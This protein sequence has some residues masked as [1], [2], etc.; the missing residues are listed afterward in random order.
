[1]KKILIL[2]GG[3]AGIYTAKNLQKQNLE[4]YEIELISDNNYFIFQPLL[5]EVASG[6]IYSSD[7]VTPIRQMLKGIK[8]R[9]AEISSLDFNNKRVS[10]LQGFKKSTHSIQYDHLIIAL[11]QVSNLDIVKGLKDHAFTMRSLQDAYDLRNHIL[12]CLELADVTSN[13]GLKKR[14]LNIVVIGGGFSGVETIGEI[15]EMIDRLIPYYSSIKKS[16]L[17]FHIVEFADQ[18]LPDM[19]KKVGQYTLK[20]FK[21]NNINVHLKTALEE[22]TQYQVFL[23]NKKNI[24]THTVISTIG[25]TV[26]K[27]IKDC[28]L[29]LQ[30]GKIITKGS[31]EVEGL[32]NV[33]AV[34]DAALIPNKDKKNMLY[35]KKKIAYAPPNAQ[36]AVRQGKLLA[37][38]IKAKILGDNLS[39]FH[40]TSK[41][42]LA[43]L[44]SR[45]GVG[46]IFF[47]TV[48]G[49]IAWLIWRAFYL[50]FLPSFA[51]KIRVLTGWIVE[52]LV[53]RNAVMTRALKNDAV[54]YQ[55]FKKGDVVFKEGM[56]AD[57]F[58]IV[59]K[60]SFKNTFTKTSSG[61]KF[62]KFY[63]VNDHFGARVLLSGSRRT[64][65]IE[66][67]EDSKVVKI[68]R[69][70][71]KVM[72]KHF[73]PMKDYF[74]N[75]IK[76]NF[77]K[78]D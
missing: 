12:G 42:S 64:G 55:N 39:D 53:P 6:T 69:D 29:A 1:M 63:K 7:A 9:N 15:K 41:G 56:I 72:N 76:D 28:N 46:K 60:G 50:S 73:I 24:A 67:L 31:L 75:Y 47:I 58:Y 30:H 37:K 57:G 48:K 59:I 33:W 11:G 62:T 26:S 38:N 5:P 3:F 17:K 66:A 49:F 22:V 16:D 78:L 68:D 34:G 4:G 32:D 19:D 10:I 2:G 8:Y 52:F 43:S 13:K 65:T 25:S 36:F 71:F 44:G 23:S 27:L 51:T 77:K 54:V 61:K 20:K 45:D 40:Y 70:T 21:K 14:L 35:K 74:T 18:L